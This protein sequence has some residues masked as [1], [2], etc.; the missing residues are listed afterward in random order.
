MR[1][2]AGSALS[3]KLDLRRM[4]HFNLCG[5]VVCSFNLPIVLCLSE[6]AQNVSFRQPT[7]ILCLQLPTS[8]TNLVS[9]AF[10]C[11]CIVSLSVRI[12]SFRYIS[13]IGRRCCSLIVCV[14]YPIMGSVDTAT[15]HPIHQSTR[16]TSP[17]PTAAAKIGTARIAAKTAQ[18]E[19]PEAQLVST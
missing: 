9:T 15:R 11:F 13:R 1:T 14:S 10:L 17:S 12:I 16:V 6:Q 18:L 4:S 8:G 7:E 5:G 3:E 2:W 19:G